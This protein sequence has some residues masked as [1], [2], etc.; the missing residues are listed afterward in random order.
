MKSIQ[1]VQGG[2]LRLA[3]RLVPRASCSQIDGWLESGELKVR[4]TGPPVDEAANMELI[5]FLAKSLGLRR[6][7]LVM[8]SGRHSRRK[9][10]EVPE[11]CKNRL[12]SFEDI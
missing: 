3:V 2:R 10:L 9:W 5:R 1:S 6:Q 4:V 12:L 7:D 8:I 11:E